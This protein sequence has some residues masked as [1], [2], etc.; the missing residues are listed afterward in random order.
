MKHNFFKIHIKEQLFLLDIKQIRL[1]LYK[2][3]IGLLSFELLNHHYLQLEEIEAINSFS[4]MIYPPILPLEKAR[5]EW[6]PES[7]SMRLNK[8]TY[9]EELFYCR[10]L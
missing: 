9:I 7:V 3:G 4:K 5:N 6:F 1:K 10:L 8:E 2:T